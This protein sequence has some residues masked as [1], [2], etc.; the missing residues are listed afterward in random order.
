MSDAGS[1][2]APAPAPAP[3][4]GVAGAMKSSMG[5]VKQAAQHHGYWLRG[6]Q[7]SPSAGAD[8]RDVKKLPKDDIEGMVDRLYADAATRQTR[9]KEPPPDRH[10]QGGI[11][12]EFDAGVNRYRT[13]RKPAMGLGAEEYDA[14]MHRLNSEGQSKHNEAMQKLYD[15]YVPDMKVGYNDLLNASTK[16]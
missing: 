6:E 4:P 3:P 11:T 5:A 12:F 14:S 1:V 16:K 7:P 15:K 2:S 13:V 9:K 10:P 8:M